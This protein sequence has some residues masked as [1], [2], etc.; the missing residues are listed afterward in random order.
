M[1][2]TSLFPGAT[3][4]LF[5]QFCGHFKFCSPFCT[6]ANPSGSPEIGHLAEGKE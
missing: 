6:M 4:V 5:G 2:Q 1:W 3:E